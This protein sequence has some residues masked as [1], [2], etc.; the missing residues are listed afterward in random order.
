[1][2]WTPR[3]DACLLLLQLDG[4][5]WTSEYLGVLLESACSGSAH[6][7]SILS[8]VV[9]ASPQ[10]VAQ[11]ATVCASKR[12]IVGPVFNEALA[13]WP[14]YEEDIDSVI[15]TLEVLKALL[16]D[17]SFRGLLEPAK[18][19]ST[20]QTLATNAAG[21]GLDAV[22]AACKEVLSTEFLAGVVVAE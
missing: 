6:V 19:A 3:T 14:L 13:R 4:H 1:M 18:T 16:S 17:S 22:V 20:I 11:V 21:D 12:D 9:A 10:L 15:L 5:Q 2:R 8:S 7:L